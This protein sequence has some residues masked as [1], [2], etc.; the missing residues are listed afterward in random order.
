MNAR[1]GE[2]DFDGMPALSVELVKGLG[3]VCA[4]SSSTA[5]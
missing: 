2:E 5:A 4:R 1:D 3:S